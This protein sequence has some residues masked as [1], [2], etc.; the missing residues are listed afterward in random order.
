MREVGFAEVEC[1]ALGGRDEPRK[2]ASFATQ[3]RARE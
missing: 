3:S 2:T 1:G